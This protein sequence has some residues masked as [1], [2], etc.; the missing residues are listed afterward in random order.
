MGR[1]ELTNETKPQSSTSLTD[2]CNE[3]NLLENVLRKDRGDKTVMMG[4]QLRKLNNRIWN[5]DEGDFQIIVHRER[6]HE[7]NGRRTYKLAR[8]RTAEERLPEIEA[9]II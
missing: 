3:Q 7:C 2:L 6:D 5:T 8:L 1:H 4:L 9:G